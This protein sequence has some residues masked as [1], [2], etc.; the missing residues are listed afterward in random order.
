MGVATAEAV[1][2]KCY[3]N[4]T[5]G[6]LGVVKLDHLGAERGHPVEPYGQVWLSDDEAIL[7]ARAPR[8]PKDNP[9]VE[10]TFQFYDEAG[11]I[12]SAPMRPLVL[13]KDARYSPSDER[14]VPSAPVTDEGQAA[15]ARD[16]QAA[17]AE[18]TDRPVPDVP[19]PH[20][21][22]PASGAA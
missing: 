17:I 11:K 15:A 21:P 18:G 13:V 14:F 10:Q 4:N 16:A 7:T 3:R 22:I 9:F 6:W 2:K 12:V 20:T 5:A 1:E 19:G 8:D